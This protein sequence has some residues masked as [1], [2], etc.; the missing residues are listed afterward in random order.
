MD[1]NDSNKDNGQHN[2]SG[3]DCMCPNPGSGIWL[4]LGF[5]QVAINIIAVKG[6]QASSVNSTGKIGKLGI[7]SESH[8][9]GRC[10]SFAKS[11]RFRTDI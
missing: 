6:I 4:L 5:D 10:L 1:Q 2:R 11:I 9:L 3:L 8:G 7:C